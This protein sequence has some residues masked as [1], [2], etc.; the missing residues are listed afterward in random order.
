MEEVGEGEGWK[1]IIEVCRW[2]VR[3]ADGAI[4][5]NVGAVGEVEKAGV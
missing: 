2:V 4:G 1:S 3:G 5:Q